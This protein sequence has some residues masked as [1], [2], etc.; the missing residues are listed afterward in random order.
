MKLMKRWMAFL[1][2]CVLLLGAVPVPVWAEQTEAH[3]TIEQNEVPENPDK[4]TQ[5]PDVSGECE[6]QYKAVV[7]EPSCT[8][9][10]YTT[11]TCT[12]CKDSYEADQTQPVDCELKQV[13][14]VPATCTEEG[15]KGYYMCVQCLEQYWDEDGKELIVNTRDL[16][17]CICLVLFMFWVIFS[18]LFVP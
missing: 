14:P 6:H 11:Y 3:E 12:L 10:G 1:L 9:G 5:T 4:N 2:A 17:I 18:A 15:V 7:T 13:A 16:L 8:T